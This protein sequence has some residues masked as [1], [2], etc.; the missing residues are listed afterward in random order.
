RPLSRGVTAS[1]PSVSRWNRLPRR[2][3]LWSR[4]KMNQELIDQDMADVPSSEDVASEQAL[5]GAGPESRILLPPL[6][7]MAVLL[8]IDGT[9]LDLAPTPREVWVPPG[10]ADTLSG[11]LT[12]TSGALALV[13]GR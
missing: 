12:Q 13:S 4:M 3:P 11:L 5:S 1:R 7:Q 2:L 10:L 6:D 9:L 8:D